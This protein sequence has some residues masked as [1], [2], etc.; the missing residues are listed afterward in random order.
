MRHLLLAALLLPTVA[1]AVPG[2]L[3]HQ[4]R[5]MDSTGLPLDGDLDV[6]VS[7]FDTE[8][9][10]TAAWTQS[11]T[12]VPFDNGYFSLTLT[13]VDDT[14]FDGNKLWL[15]LS[16]DGNTA[17]ARQPIVSV[18]YALRTDTATNVVG[19]IADVGEIRISGTTVID[20]AGTIDGSLVT[21]TLD[22]ASLPA[23]SHDGADLIS[24][25]VDIARL[26]VGASATDVAAGDHL[27]GFTEVTGVVDIS[28]LPV[29]SSA[30]DVAAGDH[31]HSFTDLTDVAA[32][33]QLPVG[34]TGSDVAAGDHSHTAADV[35]ALPDTG[36]TLGG[37]LGVSGTVSIGGSP[38]TCN[39]AAAGT[40]ALNGTRMQL[41][42]GTAWATLSVAPNGASPT[43]AGASCAQLLADNPGSPDGIYWLGVGAPYEAYCDMA[44]GGWTLVL[45]TAA[46]D[47]TFLYGSAIW[48]TTAVANETSLDT[49]AANAKLEAFNSVPFTEIQGCTTA[50]GSLLCLV[51]DFAAS[52]GGP[53]GSAL[54]LF[55]GPEISVFGADPSGQAVAATAYRDEFYTVFGP[56][57]MR[58]CLPKD[59]GFNINANGNNRARWGFANNIPSQTCQVTAAADADGAIGWGLQGQ[60]AG[61][62]GAGWT[63]YFVNDTANGGQEGSFDSWLWVR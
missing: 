32:I 50:T 53:Y 21:G 15:E 27:H 47:N 63:N 11:W 40:L 58:D 7:V 46:G 51:H 10:G 3:T 13:G 16:V 56:T 36:G 44:N 49:S 31:L 18:P 33:G 54:D 62:T 6:T 8:T 17:G 39:A 57:G 4:G 20:S 25:T 29:G 9:G 12:A 43:T 52:G 59:L 35:G 23:H 41:C 5:L 61:A 2:E 34:T 55:S 48:T 26:P 60:D 1:L 24:G 37:D 28:Q 19:G 30:A 42:D 38:G 22:P 45:K 14:V